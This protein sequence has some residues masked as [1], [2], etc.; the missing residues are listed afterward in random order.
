MLL[1]SSKVL[2]IIVNKHI[3]MHSSVKVKYLTNIIDKNGQEWM[4]NFEE[5]NKNQNASADLRPHDFIVILYIVLEERDPILKP[6][7]AV[8]DPRGPKVKLP[9]RRSCHSLLPRCVLPQATLLIF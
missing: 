7:L 6:G 1:F 8:C 4:P 5:K 2:Q 9:V 3:H